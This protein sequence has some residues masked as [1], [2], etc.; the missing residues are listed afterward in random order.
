MRR[1]PESGFEQY[2]RRVYRAVS[3]TRAEKKRETARV[4][5]LLCEIPHAETMSYDILCAAAGTPESFAS[6]ISKPPNPKPARAFGSYA[7]CARARV[8]IRRRNGT[9][10]RKDADRRR[11][12]ELPL[13]RR[14]LAGVSGKK[15]GALAVNFGFN[16]AL[17]TKKHRTLVLSVRCDFY[18]IFRGAEALIQSNRARI[19]FWCC[20]V[21]T[22]ISLTAKSTSVMPCSVQ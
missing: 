3:G 14:Q 15:P 21:L 4:Q 9:S 2:L 13:R 8:H 5:S 16:G 11:C 7:D 19:E 6:G 12:D 10:A 18:A 1:K 22:A 20:S 17:Q